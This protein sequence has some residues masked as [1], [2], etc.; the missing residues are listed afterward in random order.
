MKRE[1]GE[2][3]EQSRCCEPPFPTF[4]NLPL[5]ICREGV[6]GEAAKSEDLPLQHPLPATNDGG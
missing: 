4:N 6:D 1:S 5:A 3:P 2:S